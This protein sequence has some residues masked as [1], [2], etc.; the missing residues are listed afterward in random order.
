M[1][2]TSGV[3]AG[4]LLITLGLFSCYS[5]SATRDSSS[6]SLGK[7]DYNTLSMGDTTIFYNALQSGSIDLSENGIPNRKVIYRDHT[8]LNE[9]VANGGGQIFVHTCINR[10]G[11]SEFVKIDQE[12]TTIEDRNSLATALKMISNYR[13]E[14]DTLAPEYQCGML[15]LFLDVNK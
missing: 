12:N 4:I 13:F 5:S 7:I 9:L 14:K 1:K 2:I 10:A 11:D 6:P 15:K 8:S 3:I